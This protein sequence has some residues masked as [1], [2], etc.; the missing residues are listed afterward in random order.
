MVIT[1][2]MPG[3]PIPHLQAMLG[4]F[5]KKGLP[6][7]CIVSTV[8]PN[9]QML[10]PDSELAR[11]LRG[12]FLQYSG[13]IE[14]IGYVPGLATQTGF[15]QARSAYRAR[16]ALIEALVPDP[17]DTVPGPLLQSIACTH[18][19]KPVSPEGVRSAGIRNV[20]VLPRGSADVSSEYWNNGVLR[21]FGGVRA[22]LFAALDHLGSLSPNQFQNVILLSVAK[23][24]KK[25]EDVVAAAAKVF[26]NVALRHEADQWTTNMRLCELQLRDGYFTFERRVGLHLFEPPKGAAHMV[27]GFEAFK[28]SLRSQRIAF[29]TG[30]GE[31]SEP[32]DL[33]RN[34][35]WVVT[36][37][38][39]PRTRRF[40]PK[41]QRSEI[42]VQLACSDTPRP[43]SPEAP[44]FLG[45][46]VAIALNSRAGGQ[47]GI[48]DCGK[49]HVPTITA[50]LDGQSR[51]RLLQGAGNTN[52]LVLA[53]PPDILQ[54]PAQRNALIGELKDLMS[55]WVTKFVP[56]SDFARPIAPTGQLISLYRHTEAY[57]PVIEKKPRAL[58]DAQRQH[59]LEDAVTAWSYF[60]RVTDKRTGLC[61]ATV[62]YAGGTKSTLM[63]A[64]M[65]DVSSH[66]NALMAAVDL[67]I[68]D[69]R[70]F[71]SGIEKIVSNIKGVTSG[72]RRLPSEWIKTD[73]VR[74]G[75]KNFD[76]C[77]AGRILAALR[78]LSRH[79]LGGEIAADLIAS[80]DLDQIIKK[81]IVYSVK[82]GELV[83]TF[84]SHCAH[85]AA[86]AFRAWGFDVASPYEV[87]DGRPS[88]DGKMALLEVAAKIGPLGAEPLLL[89]ALD[90]G[91]TPE[92]TYL[93][94]VLFA[95]QLR[96]YETTGE[97][98]CV[99]EG[100]IDRSPWFT[101][102]GL[103]FDAPDRTWA[104]D[105][106]RKNEK[107]K[108]KEFQREN[109]AISP[110]AAFLWYAH[111]PHEFSDL[112][113]DFVRNTAKTTIGFASNIYTKTGKP[114]ANYADINTN[115]IILQAV[116]RMLRDPE[117]AG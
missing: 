97:L 19:T 23:N 2:I 51:S 55:N 93:A 4:S 117:Q 89:E 85:Y 9:G 94:Q 69:E 48:D 70:T 84:V 101:Y 1:D 115:G 86:L 29:S 72:G 102:Q 98:V 26:A 82:G 78:N 81:R 105:T 18:T 38:P 113:L 27:S 54:T 16:K 39:L 75:N 5:L 40:G 37:G 80:W 76:G 57:I 103:Q 34:G 17:A 114:T 77:D 31:L 41:T 21:L 99:S 107:Y 33:P 28:T 15:F 32:G 20:L 22:D 59:L 74:R 30:P 35:Y 104:I 46:G 90:F 100:P 65:W 60:Y 66:I 116:A 24:L 61:P 50:S 12:Y 42:L 96:E 64:T 53:I 91:L 68:I 73:R 25:S 63:S 10:T 111:N 92:S 7:S 79:R 13:L 49:L 87:F 109:R 45:A 95:A 110:K 8:A 52:D 83:S 71:S 3:T 43:M 67:D 14:I 56:V 62:F 44:G 88:C 112:L 6:V 36:E 108:T 58:T 11:L 106:V 47:Q